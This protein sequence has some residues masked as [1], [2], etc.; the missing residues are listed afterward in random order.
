MSLTKTKRLRRGRFEAI[1]ADVEQPTIDGLLEE[2]NSK[3]DGGM[4]LTLRQLVRD[5]NEVDRIERSEKSVFEAVVPEVLWRL[6]PHVEGLLKRIWRIYDGFGIDL[7]PSSP[8]N[9]LWSFR[10]ECPG[11]RAMPWIW[12][13]TIY[14]LAATGRLAKVRECATCRR[15]FFAYSVK[16][17]FR[18]HNAAC[19]DKYYRSTPEGKAKRAVFMERYRRRQ[20]ALDEEALRGVKRSSS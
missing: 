6:K 10:R 9:S 13:T 16:N 15:W 11:G 14:E 19:R 8:H 5:M 7:T 4:A 2:L 17:E 12:L 20:K 1:F 3:S 18:F